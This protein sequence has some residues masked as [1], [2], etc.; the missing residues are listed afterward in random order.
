MHPFQN[1]LCDLCTQPTLT[2]GAKELN[3]N[4]VRKRGAI[5]HVE[6]ARRTD[7]PMR[8]ERLYRQGGL[9][10]VVNAHDQREHQTL[11]RPIIAALALRVRD[12]REAYAY[13]I[14]RGAW[15]VSTQVEAMK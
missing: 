15:E 4:Y 5:G 6:K 10:V 8:E 12:A 7:V 13:A 1:H 3:A 14:E 2:S 9:N 11:D